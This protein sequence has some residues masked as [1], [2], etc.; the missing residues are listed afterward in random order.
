MLYC[1]IILVFLHNLID[2]LFASYI[3]HF[4]MILVRPKHI[5][6]LVHFI[7]YC[8]FYL[9]LLLRYV[10]NLL[11]FIYFLRFEFY[12]N[13]Y[14]CLTTL[15]LSWWWTVCCLLILLGDRVWGC[16]TNLGEED[17]LL[18]VTTNIILKCYDLYH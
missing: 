14:R 6:E 2:K 16:D 4:S 11:V 15:S 17:L 12:E 18:I 7:F 5:I 3:E 10:S 13:L 9:D 8:S 1:S